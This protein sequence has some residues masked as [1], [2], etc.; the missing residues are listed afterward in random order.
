MNLSILGDKIEK[1]LSLF[2]VYTLIYTSYLLFGMGWSLARAGPVLLSWHSRYFTFLQRW[3]DEMLM[4]D[5]KDSDFG[6]KVEERYAEI[7]AP[8]DPE[9]Q[10]GKGAKNGEVRINS[11]LSTQT[12]GSGP[13][14][15]D[16]DHALGAEDPESLQQI[17]G[18]PS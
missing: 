10:S 6:A 9:T 12:S 8:P 16:V 14:T 15:T 3:K 18:T 13:V 7:T 2:W 17:V 5:I 4:K 1:V 11:A